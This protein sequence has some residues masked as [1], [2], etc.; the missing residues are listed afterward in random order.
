MAFATVNVVYRK[1]KKNS[2]GECPIHLR[3]IKN[4]KVTNISTGITVAS[5]FWDDEQ[6]IV[7]RPHPNSVRINQAI[8]KKLISYR[9]EVYKIESD[10]FKLSGRAIKEKIE[11]NKTSSFFIV[12]NEIAEK[13]RNAGSI[14]SSDKVKSIINKLKEY[15]KDKDI[16]FEEITSRYLLKYESYLIEKYKNRVN[17]IAKDM[18]FIR[19][20]FNHAI[21]QNLIFDNVNPF[22]IYKIKFEPTSRQFLT[23]E[24]IQKLEDY[25]GTRVKNKCRDICLF[26][27]FSGGIRISDVLMLKV[28][29]IQNGYID[30][31][32]LKTKTQLSHKLNNKALEIVNKYSVDKQPNDYIF[33]FLDKDLD[34][35]DL[36]EIDKRI[37]SSTTV[38]NKYLKEIMLEIG[39]TKQVSTHVFRHSFAINA[40]RKGIGIS[41]IQ[42]ILRHANIRETLIYAK[43]QNEQINEA[44]EK[45]IEE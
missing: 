25:I 21:K 16:C 35:K 44:L 19:T 43:I 12:A 7:R 45:F 38:I 24:E 2:K 41:A 29:N 31:V 23:V 39:I 9:D 10:D 13:Y 3:I 33:D 5:D 37:T 36:V 6:K 42:K 18:K 14:G 1:D 40:L 4:R 11:V 17:T 28:K 8:Q 30:I 22:K 27:Y 32:I 20:V 26:Q 34:V 15:Q